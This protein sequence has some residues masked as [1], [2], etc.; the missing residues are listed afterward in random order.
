MILGNPI[1]SSAWA[2]SKTCL[3]QLNHP[4]LILDP[5]HCHPAMRSLT[6]FMVLS[7]P[8]FISAIATYAFDTILVAHAEPTICPTAI[9]G[10]EWIPDNDY[11]VCCYKG[12][13][14]TTAQGQGGKTV[15]ACC[16][17]DA[18]CT[19]AASVMSDWSV[20]NGISPSPG[21]RESGSVRGR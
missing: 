8:K 6:L 18:T 7:A 13:T 15:Y 1:K 20:V 2:L 9:I 21:M 12:E 5:A 10:G 14:R 16:Q 19:G 3:E 17:Q 4:L 11:I